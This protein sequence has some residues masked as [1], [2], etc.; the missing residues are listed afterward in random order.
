[1]AVAKVGEE[2]QIT[3]PLSVREAL[4]LKPGDSFEVEA[5]DGTVVMVPLSVEVPSRTEHLFGRH[6][7]LWSGEDAVAYIRRERESWRD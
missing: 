6:R 4:G 7:S 3:I 5:I 2:Y 1:M